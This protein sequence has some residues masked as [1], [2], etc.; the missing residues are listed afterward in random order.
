MEV[1]DSLLCSKTENRHRTGMDIDEVPFHKVNMGQDEQKEKET[2]EV[3]QSLVLPPS[4]PTNVEGITKDETEEEGLK[5]M[6]N[7]LQKEA[8]KFELYDRIYIGQ[9]SEEETSDMEKDN[10]AYPN[11]G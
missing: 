7:R 2:L 4:D 8:E 10:L 11:F 5:K 3:T 1:L 9:L 6:E